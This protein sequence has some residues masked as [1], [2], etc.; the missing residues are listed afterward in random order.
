MNRSWYWRALIASLAS[1]L[2][3]TIS[4]GCAD[5]I[6]GGKAS[7]AA[8]DGADNR[9]DAAADGGGAVDGT[10]N[11]VDAAADGGGAGGEPSQDGSAGCVVRAE[12]Y[13]DNAQFEYKEVNNTII[14][15]RCVPTCGAAKNID[16]FFYVEAL[17]A[18]ACT[19]EP[20]CHM[21]ASPT[22]C[23]CPGEKGAVH[24]YLCECASGR[25][26]CTIAMM[27]EGVCTPMRLCQ[28]S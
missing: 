28:D 15:P 9:M 10:T 21:A 17:P 5:S 11:R 4:A 8:V 1:C 6:E 7:D 25:W 27:G 23:P 2:M 3:P 22:R 18:G 13:K 16:G 26:K 12:S 24:E 14:Y 19:T 20:A